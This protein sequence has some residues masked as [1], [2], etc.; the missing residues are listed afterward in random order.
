M[1]K[2]F[3]LLSLLVVAS[4]ALTACGG[5]TPA[6]GE[7]VVV[8]ETVIVEVPG[9]TATE[10]PAAEGPKVLNLN[11]GPGDVPTLDPAIAEERHGTRHGHRLVI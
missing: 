5:A 10:A 1:R 9:A 7:P 6:A 2:L 11:F 4:M 8:K 3:A